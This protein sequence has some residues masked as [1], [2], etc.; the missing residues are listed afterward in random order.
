MVHEILDDKYKSRLQIFV[1]DI[2]KPQFGLTR[3]Q[4]QALSTNINSIIH[5]AALVKHFG[6]YSAFYSANVRATINLLELAKEIKGIDFHYI[7]T[8][9]VL[10]LSAAT[11]PDKLFTENNLSDGLLTLN[12]AYIKTKLLSESEVI[13]YRMYGINT[14][15]YRVGNLAFMKN[16]Y[17]CQ[18]NIVDNGFYHKLNC[19]L[20][21][22]Y[23]S[24]GLSKIEI[25]PADFTAQAIIRLFDKQISY[26]T[27]YHEFN[28]SNKII[29]H[30]FSL[31]VVP[32]N[33]LIIYMNKNS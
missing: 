30:N 17:Q 19:L 26:N 16:N 7:S 15:I 21:L 24:H 28:L 10:H 9:G 12:N 25:S 8:H 27:V 11:E 5:A 18:E 29:K 4:Y 6:E 33:L 2:E 22:K 20:K 1:G 32:I 3:N 13:K 23:I 14:N 31:K